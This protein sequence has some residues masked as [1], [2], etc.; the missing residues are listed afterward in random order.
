MHGST[1]GV[2]SMSNQPFLCSAC[3]AHA[4]IRVQPNGQERVACTVCDASESYET[5]RRDL[6]EQVKEHFQKRWRD[7]LRGTSWQV[8]QSV[9]PKRIHPFYVDF[10]AHPPPP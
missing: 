5:V 9:G 3:K 10:E 6:M 7:G 8:P 1:L 2:R 4:E